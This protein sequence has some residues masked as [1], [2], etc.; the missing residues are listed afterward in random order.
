M[1]SPYIPRPLGVTVTVELRPPHL[2]WGLL[3]YLL[4]GSYSPA[5]S[6]SIT[7]Q[8]ELCKGQLWLNT[9][10][11]C[12]EFFDGAPISVKASYIQRPTSISTSS[13]CSLIFLTG[14]SLKVKPPNYTSPPNTSCA[15]RSPRLCLF[16]SLCPLS[17]PDEIPPILPLL[18]AFC[19]LPPPA[20]D[21]LFPFSLHTAF[22][23]TWYEIS[24]HLRCDWYY[25][26]LS[27]FPCLTQDHVV[28]WGQG[29]TLLITS[30]PEFAA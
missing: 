16:S 17:L 5:P 28:F 11:T 9:S 18:Q 8:K 1:P 24:W 19:L 23:L 6:P 20:P 10:F 15:I 7:C 29:W 3:Q 26:Y 14:S 12:S 22:W 30:V 21:I 27:V 2:S 4:I 25:S 13:Y